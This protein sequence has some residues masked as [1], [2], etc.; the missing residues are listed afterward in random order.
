MIN[1]LFQVEITQKWE[2]FFITLN[3]KTCNE[4]I[5]KDMILKLKAFSRLVWNISASLWMTMARKSSFSRRWRT[6]KN[7]GLILV[8]TLGIVCALYAIRTKPF[9]SNETG[10]KLLLCEIALLIGKMEP[11][12]LQVLALQH[13]WYSPTELN[14][15]YCTHVLVISPHSTLHHPQ[16]W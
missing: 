15:L 7:G 4:F 14:N 6:R 1:R 2:L 13:W 8:L 10:E 16:Y 3:V 12:L 5:C 11:V 9:S